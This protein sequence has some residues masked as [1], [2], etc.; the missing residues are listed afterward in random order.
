MKGRVGEGAHRVFRSPGVPASRSAAKGCR[1]RRARSGWAKSAPAPTEGT[2]DRSVRARSIR[3]AV[4]ALQRAIG[5]A[6]VLEI[7]D[8]EAS[9]EDAFHA[10]LELAAR[11]ERG[12]DPR[13]ITRG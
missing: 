7:G 12:A 9:A 13:R 4:D 10:L 5:S 11:I 3:E 8:L 1:R 2:E 6:D